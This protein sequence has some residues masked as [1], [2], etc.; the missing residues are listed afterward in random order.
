M[1]GREGVLKHRRTAASL[2]LFYKRLEGIR[3]KGGEVAAV[4]SA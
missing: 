2:G 4:G 3:A 1:S